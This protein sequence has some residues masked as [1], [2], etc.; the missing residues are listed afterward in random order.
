MKARLPALVAMVPAVLLSAAVAEAQ[1]R[2]VVNRSMEGVAIGMSAEQVGDH[3]GD[4]A[5]REAGPDFE[6]WRYRRPPMEVALKPD[7]VTLHTR[8]ILVRGP[9]GVGIRTPERRLKTVLGRRLRCETTAGQRLCVVGSFETGMRSTVFEMIRGRVK[10]IT[11][12][13]SVE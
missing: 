4:P 8:S 12:S 2:F 9:A 10:T 11:I 1:A 7:V 13:E 3:L 5:R 6:T